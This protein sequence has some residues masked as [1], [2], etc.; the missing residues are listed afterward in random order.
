VKICILGNA[1]SPHIKRWANYFTAKGHEVT[2]I[3]ARPGTADGVPVITPRLPF[4]SFLRRRKSFDEDRTPNLAIHLSYLSL[5]FSIR[6]ILRRLSPDIVMAMTLE[7]NG[8]LSLIAAHHPTALFHLGPKALSMMSETSLLMRLLVKRMFR[9]SDML[10]TG[11]TAG[12]ARLE[13]LG[14]MKERIHINPWGVDFEK[15]PGAAAVQGLRDELGAA[16]RR[17]FVS[18]RVL[19][20]EYDVATYVNAIPLIVA[21]HP[22][23]RFVVVGGGPEEK[24]LE[25]M[26]KELGVD[27]HVVFTG[28]V[29]FELLT[30]Y[31]SAADYYV[32]SIN[33]P[34]PTG[35]TWWGHKKRCS[36]DGNGY[37]ITLLMAIASRCV[38]LLTR[39]S[40]LSDIFND[41]EQGQLLWTP[42]DASDLARKANELLASPMRCSAIAQHLYD[43]A[44]ERFD[45]RVNAAHLEEEY[46]AKIEEFRGGTSAR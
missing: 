10:Y 26:V 16:D 18:I 27:E 6:S 28:H 42:G 37:S 20:P 39:R 41:A 14:A 2:V 11:D 29:P 31:L 40:G 15:L 25:R 44:L 4:E 43:L 36:M 34:L 13:E 38:P 21:A 8:V 22:D 5:A 33:Y 12:A 46:L 23:T 17:L 3:S 1:Q 7:T 35:R 30:T 24:V 32:D 45:W 9:V 19:L